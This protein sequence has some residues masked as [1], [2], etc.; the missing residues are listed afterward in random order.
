M[1]YHELMTE[2][3][4]DQRWYHGT[5]HADMRFR[6]DQ[7]AFFAASPKDAKSFAGK[8]GYIIEARLDVRRPIDEDRLLN[9][10][11]AL[12]IVKDAGELFSADYSD[13]PDVSSF[14]DHARVRRHLEQ[15]G[16]DGYWGTDGYFEAAVVW[17]PDLIHV[18]RTVPVNEHPGVGHE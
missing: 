13:F 14:L 15:L 16:Y 7:P 5:D 3:V 17:N 12:G 4:Q 8:D 18:I 9:V 10:G 6:P 2:T 11:V 1:R